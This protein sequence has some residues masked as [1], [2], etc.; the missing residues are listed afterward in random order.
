VVSV[1]PYAVTYDDQPHSATYTVAGVNGEAGAAVGTVTL[2]GPHTDAGTYDDSWSFAGTANY[3]NIPSTALTDVIYK[4]PSTTTVTIAGGPLTYTGLPQTPAV[5]T[6]TGVGGLNL[7]PAAT[8]VDNVNAG[9]ATASYAYPG[10]DN[11][12]AS[13]DSQT[14]TIGR[15]TAAVAVRGYAGG[16]YDGS[17]HT[18]TLTVTGVP[19]DG[20]LYADSLTGTNAGIYG[21]LWF[22]SNPNYN[23]V[24]GNLAFTIAKAALTITANDDTKVYGTL[25]TF[26]STAF[27]E[28]GL[29]AADT[30]VGVTET[31]TGAAIAAG[32]GTYPIVPSAATGT[33]LG[34]YDITYVNGVLTVV[35]P[36]TVPTEIQS[37][38]EDVDKTIG[39]ISINAGLSGNLT[40]TL[41]VGHGTLTLGTASGLTVMGNGT[42]SVSL[43]GNTVDLNAA[44]AALVYRGSLNFSAADTL[45]LTL[46]NGDFSWTANVAIT[47]VSA[48]KQAIDLQGQ[49]NALVAAGRLTAGQGE[50]LNLNLRDNNGDAGKVQAFLNQLAAYIGGGILTQAEA[51]SLLGGGNILLLSVS[52]R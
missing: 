5:V 51:G 1:T 6:V 29:V 2:S 12:E 47:V 37:A 23:R 15:A 27:T 26:G 48:A 50:A 24:D 49:V 17:A 36:V 38:D 8:Y 31:S 20:L 41:G 11:H 28:T 25:K 43:T 32:V 35:P 16:I 3:E 21:L 7:T 45:T 13:S 14:F 34:N 46:G 40:L 30:V 10:D 52:R 39:G 9:T 4:A 19:H 22:Y 42:G 44:L 18:Q 33:G